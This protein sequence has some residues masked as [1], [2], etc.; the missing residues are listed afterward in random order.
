[1]GLGTLAR[2][3]F[4]TPNDRKV[5]S[6]RPI[7]EAVRQRGL[8]AVREYSARF[9]GVDQDDVLVPWSHF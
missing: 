1:M 8:E 7:V 3:I 9:D 6:V 5:K 2:S 4:G